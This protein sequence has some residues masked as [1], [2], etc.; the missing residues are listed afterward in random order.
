MITVHPSYKISENDP[1]FADFL[2]GN[3]NKYK[4]VVR[5][6]SFNLVRIYID[7]RIDRGFILSNDELS[8]L[9]RSRLNFNPTTSDIDLYLLRV[10]NTVGLSDDIV[11]R[12]YNSFIFNK[13][14]K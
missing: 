7:G 5:N 13:L 14:Q 9:V 11:Q 6:Y 10:Y 4:E 2:E 12:N 8:E 1:Y 3:Q